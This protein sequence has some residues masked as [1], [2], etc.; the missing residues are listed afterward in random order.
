[1]KD[2]YTFGRDSSCDHS[3]DVTSAKR[4]PHFAAISKTHFR[5]FRVR[6]DYDISDV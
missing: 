4:T 2:E 1:M 3:F 6:S 5:I